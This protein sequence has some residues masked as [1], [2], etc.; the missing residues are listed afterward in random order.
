MAQLTAILQKLELTPKEIAVFLSLTRLGKTTATAIGRSAGLTRTHVYDIVKTLHTKGLVSEVEERGIKTYEAA[1]HAGL[2]AF[3]SRKQKELKLIEKKAEQSVNEFRS[4]QINMVQ[5]TKVRF[6]DGPEGVKHIYNEIAEDLNKQKEPFEFISLF[7]P[8][9]LDVIIPEF[10][11]FNSPHMSGREI[12]AADTMIEEYKKQIG[13]LPNM[14]HKLWPKERGLFPT[15]TL[16]WKNKLAYIDLAGYPSGIIIENDA[17]AKSFTMWFNA[18][19]DS[20]PT[21]TEQ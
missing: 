15:D 4:L 13:A 19:W 7:S 10:Q 17:M 20:L 2:M 6:F 8:E 9:Q 5:K 11:Y 16:V 1:D 3:I 18:I 21:P 12:V 14:K